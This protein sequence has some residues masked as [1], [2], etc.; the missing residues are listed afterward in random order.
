VDEAADGRRR[1]PRRQPDARGRARIQEQA[2][3]QNITTLHNRVNELGVAEPVIQ[4]QGLDRVVVQLPGVQDTA[5][6]KDIIGRTATLEIRMVN[7]S[8]E[9]R[10]AERGRAGALRQRART[11]SAAASR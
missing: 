6:A 5:K 11:S 3:K 4:Q 9:A 2:L 1:A 7:E 10:E 8:A